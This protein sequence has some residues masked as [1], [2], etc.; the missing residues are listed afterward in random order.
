LPLALAEVARFTN[1]DF[2]SHELLHLYKE[3]YLKELA[4]TLDFPI[5][6]DNPA[7]KEILEEDSNSKYITPIE[8]HWVDDLAKEASRKK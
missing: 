6:Y 4:R 2:I 8:H 5:D 7:L 1:I 3:M